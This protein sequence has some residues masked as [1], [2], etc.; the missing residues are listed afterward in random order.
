PQLQQDEL[1][2]EVLASRH[3]LD[4]HHVH[5]LVE[6]IDD[7]LDDRFRAGGDQGEP[8]YCRII[9][10]RDGERLYVV[11]TSGEEPGYPAQGTGL[12]LQENGD[13]MT[14]AR[15]DGP[16][17]PPEQRIGRPAAIA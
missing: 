8:R 14:H 3:V 16:A 1:A 5:Q 12:V 13:D 10:R 17:T 2:L 11:A 7:L 6:L 4:I 9:R 15:S